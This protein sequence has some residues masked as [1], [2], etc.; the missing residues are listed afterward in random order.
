MGTYPAQLAG[1]AA[2]ERRKAAEGLQPGTILAIHRTYDDAAGAYDVTLAEPANGVTLGSL[3]GDART[4]VLRAVQENRD[5]AV[6]VQQ[7]TAKGLLWWR[8]AH[9]ALEILTADE[10]RAATGQDHRKTKQ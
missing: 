6:R 3:E 5:I 10:A 8:K 7:A 1:I 9:V 4:R 2:P